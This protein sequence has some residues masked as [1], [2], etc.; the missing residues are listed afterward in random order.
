MII[1][2]LPV[3]IFCAFLWGYIPRVFS[4][5]HFRDSFY[6][7]RIKFE[8]I[9]N[10][11]KYFDGKPKGDFSLYK[12]FE[13]DEETSYEI[14]KSICESFNLYISEHF[15]SNDGKYNLGFCMV[16]TCYRRWKYE[17]VPVYGCRLIW[18][19]KLKGPKQAI[20]TEDGEEYKVKMRFPANSREIILDF[21]ADYRLK[22]FKKDKDEQDKVKDKD[23]R[24]GVGVAHDLGQS[25]DVGPA[26]DVAQDLDLALQA[27]LLHGPHDLDDAARPRVAVDRLEHLAVL[28]LSDLG[29]FVFVFCFFVVVGFVGGD[30]WVER[31]QGGKAWRL[32]AHTSQLFFQKK[33]GAKNSPGR[34]PRTCPGSPTRRRR[35]R[36]STLAAETPPRRRTAARPS[37]TRCAAAPTLGTASS[38]PFRTLLLALSA[39][40]ILVSLSA[41]Y[42]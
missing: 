4:E 25:D 8:F 19:Y 41:L 15:P 42:L 23:G 14:S 35:R 6:G 9:F 13:F 40:A 39:A 38:A 7:Y 17:S 10:A 20:I 36:S 31:R 12:D 34:A 1:I 3:C 29:F 21:L 18:G 16:Q 26:G 33:N 30:F 22:Q 37:G 24:L 5:A 27:R 28:A 2:F 11:E 32:Q